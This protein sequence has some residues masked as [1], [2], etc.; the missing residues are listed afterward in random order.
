MDSN[1][2]KM[3]SD[4]EQLYI[5]FFF[6]NMELLLSVL[7]TNSDKAKSS[8]TSI[9]CVMKNLHEKSTENFTTLCYA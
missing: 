8:L 3:V 2:R 7:G 5:R 4:F 6:S 1:Y 9:S